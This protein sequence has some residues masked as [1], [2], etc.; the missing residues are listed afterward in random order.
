MT[1]THTHAIAPD[2][3]AIIRLMVTNYRGDSRWFNVTLGSLAHGALMHPSFERTL[4][5]VLTERL[6]A[7]PSPV[8][9][10]AATCR[11]TTESGPGAVT[12]CRA[13]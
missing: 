12:R 2:K 13:D 4:S 9:A 1:T 3:E 8:P 11:R 7:P 6:L 10:A 5:A